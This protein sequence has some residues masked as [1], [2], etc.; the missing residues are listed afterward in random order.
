MPEMEPADVRGLFPEMRQFSGQCRYSDCIHIN[1]P[2]CAVKSAVEDGTI[3]R[4]RYS[5]YVM[6]IDEVKKWKK[7]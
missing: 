6:M 3:H 4:S 2:D 1:E 5:S 7:L